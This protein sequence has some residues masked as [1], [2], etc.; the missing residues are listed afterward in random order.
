[1][2]LFRNKK[3][4]NKQHPRRNGVEEGLYGK[5]DDD[6]EMEE[7]RPVRTPF[8]LLG[9]L[10]FIFTLSIILG[11]GWVVYQTWLPQ[12]LSDL[13]G[14]RQADVAPNIPELLRQANKK[15]AALTLTESDVNRY[16][17]STLKASQNGILSP[18]ARPNGVGI[19]FHDNYMEIIIERRIG[20]ST[21]QTVSM[22][23]TIVQEVAGN[24]SLPVTRLEFCDSAEKNNVVSRGGTLG[25]LVVPQGYM[26][27]LRPAFENLAHAYKDIL[28][29]IVDS[30]KIIRISEGRVDL[31]PLPQQT[32]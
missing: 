17:A 28:D 32:F 14:Y 2:G 25:R 21:L 16:L 10:I 6:E 22:Y 13:P 23:I 8:S 12:D 11:I 1:M 31:L 27:V 3:D 5:D 24:S 9:N 15:N 29:S 26:I 19:R 7:E 18:L 30:G 4:K 20:I